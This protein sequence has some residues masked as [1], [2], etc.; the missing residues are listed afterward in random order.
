MSLIAIDAT[1]RPVVC[2]PYE[3]RRQMV[4]LILGAR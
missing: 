2:R 4:L 1:Q 3:R